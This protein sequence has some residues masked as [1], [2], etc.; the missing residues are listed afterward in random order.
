MSTKICGEKKEF[1]PIIY[2]IHNK[3]WPH[4]QH[5][6]LVEVVCTRPSLQGGEG[7]VSSSEGGDIAELVRA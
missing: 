7:H 3:V 2:K 6:A 1:I 4:L 5:H